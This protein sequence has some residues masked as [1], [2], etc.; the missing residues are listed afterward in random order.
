MVCRLLWG[1]FLAQSAL[2]C[3]R[4]CLPHPPLGEARWPEALLLLLAA[5]LTLAAQA[6]HAP[7]QNVALATTLILSL[8]GLAMAVAARAAIPLGPITG[9]GTSAGRL[10]GWLPW[11]AALWL[12]ALLTS[13][14]VARLI[15]RPWR[16]SFTYGFQVIGLTV[17]LF[18][19]FNSAFE[20]F[21][22]GVAHG[23][24]WQS[25]RGGDGLIPAS[26]ASC[27]EHGW[28][29]QGGNPAGHRG[30]MPWIGLGAQAATA[31][32]ILIFATPSLLDKRPVSPPPDS[33]PLMIWGFANLLF[34]TA[35]VTR[36]RWSAAALAAS[37]LAVVT[38]L[39]LRQFGRISSR[40]RGSSF[41]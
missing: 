41:R 16:A 22:S 27:V 6:R 33:F 25:S 7:C 5:G 28:S 23:W 9:P 11:A 13:R 3:A 26:L 37:S 10:L 40:V 38:L 24:A 32:F 34:T 39:C 30:G 17:L 15:L 20:P 19:L 21:A 36:H 12:V 8:A 29:C 1:L 2:V 35:A 31:L 14:G 4:V 18:V